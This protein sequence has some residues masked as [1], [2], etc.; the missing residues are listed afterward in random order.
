MGH[1]PAGNERREEFI[2]NGRGQFIELGLEPGMK[3]RS[4][5]HMDSMLYRALCCKEHNA[6]S[7]RTTSFSPFNSHIDS[8]FGE[9]LST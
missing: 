3:I 1:T 9:G 6:W 4:P 7:G 8:Q 5:S 2:L